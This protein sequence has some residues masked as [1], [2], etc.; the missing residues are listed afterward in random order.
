MAQDRKGVP[1]RDPLGGRFGF[2]D[3]G[4]AGPALELNS[5]VNEDP[6]NRS[7]SMERRRPNNRRPCSTVNPNTRTLRSV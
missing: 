7:G 1:S 2:K 5:R 4:L 6:H 3:G